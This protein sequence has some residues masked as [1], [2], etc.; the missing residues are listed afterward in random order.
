MSSSKLLKEFIEQMDAIEAG[1]PVTEQTDDKEYLYGLLDQLEDALN[2]AVD[3]ANQLGR[4]SELRGVIGSYTR[5]WLEA[6]A[7]DRHQ[8]GSVPN[9]RSRLEEDDDYED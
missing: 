9:L 3:I 1:K 8:M 2:N 6:W 5:P 4:S 7:S